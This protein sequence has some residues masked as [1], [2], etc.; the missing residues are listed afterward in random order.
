MVLIMVV[1]DLVVIVL[2]IGNSV[3]RTEVYIELN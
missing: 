2:S 1:V 3:R